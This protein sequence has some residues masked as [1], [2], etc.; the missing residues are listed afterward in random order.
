MPIQR[1]GAFHGWHWMAAG[2]GTFRK[3]PLVWIA[4]VLILFLVVQLARF[5]PFL[6][7]ALVLLYPSLLAGFMTGCA[8]LERGRELDIAHLLAGFHRKHAGRLIAIGGVN[9]LGNVLIIGAM[10][11]IGG[12][13]MVQ[14]AGGAVSPADAAAVEGAFG[15]V[16]AALLF[17]TLLSVPLLMAI[18]F[19]PLLVIFANANP[20]RALKLSFIACWR[21]VLPF[22]GYG[23]GILGLI[24]LASLPF[25]LAGAGTSAGIWIALPFVLPSMYAAYR[26]IF[27]DIV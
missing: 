15:R 21:N 5:V 3:S 6:G 16:L 4:F 7:A 22:L 20:F 19:A 27:R 14:L 25:G 17:A 9:L 11:L 12:P 8:D 1:V 13:A 26:D 2:F 10:L 23:V 24:V 18:W